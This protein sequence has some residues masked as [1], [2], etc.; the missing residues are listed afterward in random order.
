[1]AKLNARITLERER[2]SLFTIIKVRKE[3]F[4]WVD[5]P[6]HQDKAESN[7]VE[8]NIYDSVDWNNIRICIWN[9]S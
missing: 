4:K 8:S 5:P 6:R 3:H 2:N 7:E 1:M 9:K